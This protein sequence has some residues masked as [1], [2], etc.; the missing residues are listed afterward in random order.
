MQNRR[1][2]VS[3]S[4]VALDMPMFTMLCNSGCYP[5]STQPWTMLYSWVVSFMIEWTPVSSRYIPLLHT[6]YSNKRKR[7]Y[8]NKQ[9]FPTVVSNTERWAT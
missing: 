3:Y 7:K 9:D 6:L 4:T 2:N 1:Y 5:V 8:S